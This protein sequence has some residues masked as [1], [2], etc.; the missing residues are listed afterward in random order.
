MAMNG[1]NGENNE[2]GKGRR[3]PHVFFYGLRE[4]ENTENGENKTG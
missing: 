3:K 4:G 2:Q 1:E